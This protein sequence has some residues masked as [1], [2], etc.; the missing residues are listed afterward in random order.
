MTAT[1]STLFKVVERW[2]GQWSMTAWDYD[3]GLNIRVMW[4]PQSAAS[5]LR[6]RYV[7]ATYRTAATCGE[8]GQYKGGRASLTG[9]VR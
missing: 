6:R 5:A 3:G 9:L 8:Q 2:I 1:R 4:S 7:V